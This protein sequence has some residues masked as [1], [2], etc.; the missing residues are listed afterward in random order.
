MREIKIWARLLGVESAVVERV[1]LSNDSEVVL[2]IRA[3]AEDA[4]RCSRCQR[5]CSRYDHGEGRRRWR[6]PDL[7]LVMSYVEAESPRVRCPEHGVVVAHA[8]WARPG[9]RFT[10]AFEDVT[11]WLV[12]H[13]DKTT[14]SS[15]LRVA[16]RSVGRIIQRVTAEAMSK[17]DPLDG[18]IRIGIDEVSYRR[19]HRY[20]TVVVDH[21]TGRLLWASPGR[22]EKNLRLFFDRLGPERCAA[23]ELV[24]ADAASWIASVVKERCPNA[25]RCM[26][27]FHVVKWASEAVDK[28]RRAMW[29]EARHGP[30]GKT[31]ATS[32]KHTRFALLK[33]PEDLTGP[34]CQRSCRTASAVLG[35]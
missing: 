5:P 24:S 8:P 9:A 21:D 4:E 26:D 12:T 18:V 11:A 13:T 1:E 23:I 7:G 16:W 35:S 14:V 6:A 19:G 2:H 15:L 29:N 33:N 20:L 28:V 27:P 17:V 31:T 3:Y 22:D 10:R 30:L 34:R 25:T 32:I